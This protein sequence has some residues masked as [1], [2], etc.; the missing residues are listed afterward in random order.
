MTQAPAQTQMYAVR[1]GSLAQTYGLF[2]PGTLNTGAEISADR[3]TD[4]SLRSQWFYT[5]NIPLATKRNGK[6]LLGMGGREAFNAVFGQDT[7]AVCQEL[8]NT[9][10]IQLSPR[11]RDLILRLERSGEVAFVDPKEMALK[12]TDDEYRSFPIRTGNYDNDVTVPRMPFV[13]AGYGAGDM[14]G[15]VMDNL[16]GNKISETGVY[17][18]N[19]EHAAE[20]VNDGGIVA[21]ASGLFG[22]VLDSWF[23][24]GDR[25]VG[26]RD[27]LRGVLKS[28]P[29]EGGS[30][31]S[32]LEDLVGKGT[33]AGR[34]VAVVHQKDVSPEAWALLM[35]R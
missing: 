16:K 35:Q 15:R 23:G 22:F 2:V 21:R 17:T 31:K 26:N 13:G 6:L 3:I 12:G 19:P 32:G 25:G 29:A 5:A 28:E 18:M 34:G 7:E 9:G 24:A 33:D 4:A 1:S 11:K 27:C 14:L 8:I 30:Q 10:Y 20:N